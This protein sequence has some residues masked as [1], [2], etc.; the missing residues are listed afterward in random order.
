MKKTSGKIV[1]AAVLLTAILLTAGCNKLDVV[2]SSAKTTFAEVLSVMEDN[3]Q[4]DE[5]TGSF[6]LFAS[7]FSAA[8]VWVSDF[9]KSE[10]DDAAFT[11]DVALIFDAEPFFVAGL[12]PEKLPPEITIYPDY[13]GI[14]VGVKL[15][16]EGSQIKGEPTA[17]AAFEQIVNLKRSVIG[18]HAALDH[19]GITIGNGNLF[20][21]AKDMG[22]NE[23]DIV[24]VLNPEPF[25]TAGVVIT[26]VPGWTFAKVPVDVNG[27][28]VE[29]DKLIKPFNLR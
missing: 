7:D 18:Y 23:K 14:I 20:E 2:G 19:Y 27:K 1:A 26:D 22:T 10:G 8:F 16:S 28:P 6:A 11:Y 12:D 29:V 21:W 24:F 9:S 4:S 13:S 5:G 3:L 25:I 15:G 17:L